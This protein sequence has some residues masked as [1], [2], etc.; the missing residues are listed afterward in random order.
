MVQLMLDL[1]S[2]QDGDAVR[3]SVS[4]YTQLRD[5]GARSLGGRFEIYY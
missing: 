3:A 4:I 1:C 5:C 2:E